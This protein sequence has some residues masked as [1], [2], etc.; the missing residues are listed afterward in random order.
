[1]KQDKVFEF[2]KKVNAIS[3]T[4]MTFSKCEYALDNYHE[5]LELSSTM[6]HEYIKSEVQ[7]YN[8]YCDA[9]YPTPQPCVRVVIIKDDKKFVFLERALTGSGELFN[10]SMVFGGVTQTLYPNLGI[11]ES[12]YHGKSPDKMIDEAMTALK[13]SQK[14]NINSN[15]CFFDRI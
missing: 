9:F 13:I 10:L 15:Y 11:A 3:H 8:I 4:G 5:L 6:L 2:I 1:M 12:P 14:N 7:P